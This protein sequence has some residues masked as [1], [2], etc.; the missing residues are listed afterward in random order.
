MTR[1]AAILL[2]LAATLP[3]LASPNS[4]VAAAL[5]DARTLPAPARELTRYLDLSAEY[6]Q[7]R[8][9]LGQASHFWANSLSSEDMAKLRR[10]GDDMLAVYLPD[11][12][13]TP[14]LWEKLLDVEP[15]W[16]VRLR[17]QAQQQRRFWNR[18]K[19]AWYVQTEVKEVTVSAVA[20][21]VESK[22]MAELILLTNSAVPLVRADWWAAQVATQDGAKVGY[23]DFLQ[24]GKKLAD[25]EQLV[26]L[27]R[28]LA[29]KRRKETQAIVEESEVAVH[30]R[31]L[32]RLEVLGGVYWETL[33]ANA[34]T[35]KRNALRLLNGDFTF[36][37]REIYGSLPNGLF[38]FYLANAK[39]ERQDTAP[40]D[41]ANDKQSPTSDKRVRIGL[42]CVRCH[43][44]G[45]R[46]V[47]D[48][49]R[50]TYSDDLRLDATDYGKYLRLKRIY[51]TDLVDKIKLDQAVYAGALK[52]CNGLTPLENAVAVG[53]VYYRFS[54]RRLT[55]ADV[56]FEIGVPAERIVAAIRAKALGDGVLATF[57]KQKPGVI[58]R[59]HFEEALPILWQYLG[60]K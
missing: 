50:E 25:F 37:A 23:Y 38:A 30:N 4:A 45:I 27:D 28:K 36:D 58:N 41:I 59:Q 42:S 47:K 55:L 43:V 49:A 8:K 14:E 2:M 17:I 3:A 60:Y 32:V 40:P 18:Q 24:V 22:P 6:E 19:R 31:H 34:N 35:D 48:W 10:V 7:H 51:L 16:N 11:F 52:A 44:E 21:W 9:Q 39:G 53:E 56:A 12:G 1:W 54:D 26:G 57:A 33:D 13:W 5:A 46:N 20:P 15:Y 29:D